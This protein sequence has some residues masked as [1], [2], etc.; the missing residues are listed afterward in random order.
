MSKNKIV[1]MFLVVVIAGV[2]ALTG[3]AAGGFAVYRVVGMKQTADQAIS[4]SSVKLPQASQ[5]LVLN[6]TDVETPVTQA[7]QTVSPAVVTVVGSIQG[8]PIFLGR[9]AIKP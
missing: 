6:S 1:Y 8:Q 2:S 9:Q 5:S 4:D 3:A 7:V